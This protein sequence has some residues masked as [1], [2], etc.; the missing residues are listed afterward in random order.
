MDNLNKLL[1]KFNFIYNDYKI[2]KNNYDLQ[3]NIRPNGE[4]YN[5]LEFDVSGQPQINDINNILTNAITTHFLKN[6]ETILEII[7]LYSIIYEHFINQYT[8][9]NYIYKDKIIFTLK[10][11]LSMLLSVNRIVYEMPL[12]LGDIFLKFFVNDII[13][14]SDIDFGLVINYNGLSTEQQT[15]LFNDMYNMS[16]IILHLVREHIITNKYKFSDFE[17]SELKYQQSILKEIR[18]KINAKLELTN[19]NQYCKISVNNINEEDPCPNDVEYYNTFSYDKVVVH[20]QINYNNMHIINPKKIGL[21][22]FDKQNNYVISSNIVQWTDSRNKMIKFGLVRMKVFFNL[23]NKFDINNCCNHSK[24]SGEIIDVSIPHPDY[25]TSYTIDDF[26][27]YKINDFNITMPTLNYHYNDL[28]YMLYKIVKFPWNI[29]KYQVRINRYFSLLIILL[30][31]KSNR[32]SINKLRNIIL[33]LTRTLDYLNNYNDNLTYANNR[34]LDRNLDVDKIGIQMDKIFIDIL[35]LINETKYKI[36]ED[37]YNNNIDNVKDNFSAFIDLLK[38]NIK[39]TKKFI[40]LYKNNL[41]HPNTLYTTNNITYNSGL[42]GGKKMVGGTNKTT[43]L[44]KLINI[45]SNF[46]N[47]ILNQES[48]QVFYKCYEYLIPLFLDNTPKNQV[49]INVNGQEIYNS[50]SNVSDNMLNYFGYRKRLNEDNIIP[51]MF[52]NFLVEY[53]TFLIYY[54]GMDFNT[55]SLVVNP[56]YKSNI[57]WTSTSRDQGNIIDKYKDELLNKN[58]ET[59][60]TDFNT[61]LNMMYYRFINTLIINLSNIKIERRNFIL[62][63]EQIKLIL[64]ELNDYRIN[65]NDKYDYLN[66]L[67]HDWKLRLANFIRTTYNTLNYNNI[68]ISIN[69]VIYDTINNILSQDGRNMLN[70]I[71]NTNHTGLFS[72]LYFYEDYGNSINKNRRVGCCI[73]SSTVEMYLLLKIHE[74]NSDVGFSIEVPYIN[75]NHS[76]WKISQ[77][78]MKRNMAHWC[79]SWISN[80]K[81]DTNTLF[82]KKFNFRHAYN[83]ITRYMIY[84]YSLNNLR[85]NNNNIN[86]AL[87]NSKKNLLKSFIFLPIDIKIEYL[88]QN[89]LII[90]TANANYNNVMKYD[91]LIDLA[92]ELIRLIN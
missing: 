61:E 46:K 91:L 82:V 77:R 35:N 20:N 45:T 54:M 37:E 38:K 88:R 90:N 4:N 22:N 17:K 36:T 64:F 79:G 39:N 47:I 43:I 74:D 7:N 63:I 23:Y 44:D 72:Y 25:K 50:A 29:N 89:A 62:N 76:Y 81:D 24:N 19:N 65:N 1:F 18:E 12:K 15:T 31:V 67:Y 73:N 16:F 14:K 11:G 27:K 69:F 42:I 75:V 34:F 5:E 70:E 30:L 2:N 49:F 3:I 21:L 6:R 57:V 83:N 86:N 26:Q 51:Y 9:D 10:G 33:F 41:L 55:K 68:M 92:N 53:H 59:L 60:L 56:N 71:Y 28:Y 40:S 66:Y 58:M 87:L 48:F 13:K 84:D 8:T 32:D 85:S 80:F 78:E 52:L